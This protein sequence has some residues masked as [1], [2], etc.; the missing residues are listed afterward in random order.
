LDILKKGKLVTKIK[1][2]GG[3]FAEAGLANLSVSIRENRDS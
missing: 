1:E 3:G 2:G